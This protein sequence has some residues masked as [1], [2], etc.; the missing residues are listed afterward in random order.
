MVVQLL[1]PGH[2]GAALAFSANLSVV[3][4]LG[5]HEFPVRFGVLRVDFL[6]H[7]VVGQLAW[8]ENTL[9]NI[10]RVVLHSLI[11]ILAENDRVL[12]HNIAII[13]PKHRIE[14]VLSFR[15]LANKLRSTKRVER[16]V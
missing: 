13:V 10:L 1:L 6:D 8:R 11:Q 9:A 16:I 12:G 3:H 4:I 5:T 2:D 7:A 15:L 14:Q